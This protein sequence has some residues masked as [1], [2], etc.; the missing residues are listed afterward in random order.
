MGKESAA[1]NP[2]PAFALL[3]GLSAGLGP[4]TIDSYLPAMPAIGE[5]LGVADGPI[6]LTLAVTMTGFAIGQLVIGPWSD[7]V[8]RRMPLLVGLGLLICASVTSM[9]ASDIG[10]L[11]AARM[12]QGIGASSAAVI[13]VATARDA[14]SGRALPAALSGIAIVQ[15]LAPLVAPVLGSLQLMVV[16]WRGIFGLLSLYALVVLALVVP[17]LPQNEASARSSDG[18]LVRY[19]RL[20]ADR[21]FAVLLLLAGLRFTALFT[22]LQ[23]SP[24]LLQRERGLS[25]QEFGIAFAVVTLGMMVGLQISPRA[26]RRGVSAARLLWS[27]YLILLASACLIALPVAGGLWIVVAGVVLLLGCGLGLPTIQIL[28]LAPH[29]RDAATVAGLIGASG[30]GT[31]SLLA[32]ALSVVPEIVG[33]YDLSLALVVTGVAVLSAVISIRPLASMGDRLS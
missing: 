6:Q 28:A 3:L 32:P 20:L 22:F 33:R 4:F 24:F 26:I 27:S 19:R 31:A 11:L 13:A 9:L 5:D 2:R 18:V 7:R 21:T 16:G 15:S 14:F 29:K 8:G 1:P 30:F 17:R 23:W 12:L 25:P 10:V